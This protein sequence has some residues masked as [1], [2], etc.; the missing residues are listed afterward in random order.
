[1]K[2]I[3]LYIFIFLSLFV[4]TQ[5]NYK[6]DEPVPQ[7]SFTTDIALSTP[8]G[9]QNAVVGVYGII[10]G[11]ALYGE[12]IQMASDLVGASDDFNWRGTF[13]AQRDLRNKN[14]VADNGIATATWITAYRAINA[15]NNVIDKINVITNITDR[16]TARGEV[17]FLR[18]LC[19]FDLVRLY[20]QPWDATGANTGLGV[21]LMLKANNFEKVSR[22]SITE[23]YAQVIQDLQN[24]EIL[25]P[26]TNNNKATTFAA[27]ALL[28]RVYLQQGNYTQ[29]LTKANEVIQS[30][31]YVLGTDVNTVFDGNNTS[32]AIFEI[33]QNSVNNAGQ[34]NSGLATFYS[35]QTGIGRADM[36]IRA[37]H[38]ALYTAGDKRRNDL[39]YVGTGNK[40]GEQACG[41]WKSPVKNYN[42][43][44]LAEMYLIRAE[45]NARNN[46]SIGATALADIN[47]IRNRA[48]LTNLTTVTL[49]NIL[50][51]RRLEL[52]FEGH[53]LHDLKRLKQN[54]VIL[55][56]TTTVVTTTFTYDSPKA[57]LPIPLREINVNNNLVQNPGY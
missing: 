3:N 45:C 51:E 57:V 55:N 19:H 29:A 32:E 9:V 5:C 46:T 41:K 15:A 24:A 20:A 25:L 18:A 38:L 47:T 40:P 30:G 31:S 42:I 22:N 2:K 49:N 10:A 12:S 16:N 36:E 54:I 6:L 28:A 27:K 44:R 1:M 17:L 11:S 33:Q 37:E 53:R 4:F 56:G 13:F 26:T 34:T 48:G 39:F 21:P 43:I 52:C 23:V 7:Q 8:E 14:M 35:N 50:F